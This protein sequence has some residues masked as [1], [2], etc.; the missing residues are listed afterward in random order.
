MAKE[1]LILNTKRPRGDERYKTFS[2]RVLEETVNQI[3]E[4]ASTTNR[5][6]NELINIFLEF[7]VERCQIRE[8]NN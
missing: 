8:G 5:S 2:V 7:A 6:R 3:D 4:I 1:A